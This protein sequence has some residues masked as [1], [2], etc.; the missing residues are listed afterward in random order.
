MTEEKVKNILGFLCLK[1]KMTYA[2]GEHENYMGTNAVLRTYSYYNKFGCFTIAD[3]PVR[4]DVMYYRLDSV[5]Q[6]ADILLSPSPNLGVLTQKNEKAYREYDENISKHKLQIFDFEPEIWEKHRKTGFLKM[7]FFW[8]TDKQILQAL[9][10]V[11][12]AQIEKYGSCFGI[13]VL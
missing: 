12:E 3:V 1:Y 2:L 5:D 6:I 9:A 8:G 10:D 7:P 13:K 11:I 4:G